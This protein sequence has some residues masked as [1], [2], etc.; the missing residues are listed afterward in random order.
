MM[1]DKPRDPPTTHP[2]GAA[3]AA[4]EAQNEVTRLRKENER[5]RA[6]LADLQA[7][8]D[9]MRQ[10]YTLQVQTI[11]A[12]VQRLQAIDESNVPAVWETNRRLKATLEIRDGMIQGLQER[13]TRLTDAIRKF[14]AAAGND[15]CHENRRELAAAVGDDPT[16]PAM[17]PEHEFAI[18]CITYRQE[19]YGRDCPMSEIDT[20]QREIER[21]TALLREA[22]DVLRPFA[23]WEL[24]AGSPG[25]CQ[26]VAEVLSKIDCQVGDPHQLRW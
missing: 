12:T 5:M 10:V 7:C 23:N 15:L 25:P 9:A 11:E 17:V 20:L 18:G 14:L 3:A 22:T 24:L 13:V 19:I 4:F 21:L 26:Q 6:E 1:T 8:Q 2:A 16:W